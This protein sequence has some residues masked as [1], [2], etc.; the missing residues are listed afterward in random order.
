MAKIKRSTNQNSISYSMIRKIDLSVFWMIEATNE[1]L[2]IPKAYGW[3]FQKRQL[4]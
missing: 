4:Q 2:A 3:P 1:Y